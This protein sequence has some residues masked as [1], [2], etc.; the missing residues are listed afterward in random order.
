M[1]L[2]FAEAS[3][4]VAASQPLSG[5]YMAPRTIRAG[6]TISDRFFEAAV[7]DIL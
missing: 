1:A 2:V 5:E 4:D 6:L 7:S 3:Q